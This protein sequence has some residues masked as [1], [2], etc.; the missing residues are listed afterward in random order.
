MNNLNDINYGWTLLALLIPIIIHLF[1]RS[2]GKRIVFSFVDLLPAPTKKTVFQLKL[3]QY[4]L[5]AVRL[6]LLA[7]SSIL[8]IGLYSNNTIQAQSKIAIVTD[9]WRL[10][11]SDTEKNA[12]IQEGFESIYSLEQIISESF[13][14]ALQQ[15]EDS[16]LSL[17][18]EAE[19]ALNASFFVNSVNTQ[20]A[21]A[22]AQLVSHGLIEQSDD[23]Q[24]SVF[25][26]NRLSQY[27][28]SSAG[29]FSPEISSLAQQKYDPQTFSIT[30]SELPNNSAI[31]DWRLLSLKQQTENELPDLGYLKVNLLFSPDELAQQISPYLYAAIDAINQNIPQVSLSIGTNTKSIDAINTEAIDNDNNSLNKRFDKSVELLIVETT[32]D[33]QITKTPD[34]KLIVHIEELSK[35]SFPALLFN[36]LFKQELALAE[37]QLATLPLSKIKQASLGAFASSKSDVKQSSINSKTV[38]QAPIPS[39]L[40]ALLVGLFI[41]ERILSERRK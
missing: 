10:M 16:F 35:P 15:P 4:L 32:N 26:T 41:F 21:Q 36:D 22:Y 14:E 31:F 30:R 6:L 23:T 19:Q 13:P 25:A 3:N 7:L 8:L 12:L 39:W 38:K 17:S 18:Q 37:N 34:G 27:D 2:S 40:A 11:A 24:I 28:L 33:S 5:L 9:D 1:N 20:L 29:S